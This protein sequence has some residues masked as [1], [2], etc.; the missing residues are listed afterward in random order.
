MRMASP[1]RWQTWVALAM[2]TW[3]LFDLTVPGLCTDEEEPLPLPATAAQILDPGPI[4]ARGTQASGTNPVSSSPNRFDDGCWCC[5]SH[6]APS[7]HFQTAILSPLDSQELP[8]FESSSQG[9]F[10]PPYHPPRS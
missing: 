3:A 6:V 8:V 7:P 2:L 5:C 9:W 4:I 10:A 1:A